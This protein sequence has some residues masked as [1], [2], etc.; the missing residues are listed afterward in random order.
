MMKRL[1]MLTIV[2][3]FFLSLI[4]HIFAEEAPPIIKELAQT[5]LAAIG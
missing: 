2:S 4:S 3:L 5:K 1:T